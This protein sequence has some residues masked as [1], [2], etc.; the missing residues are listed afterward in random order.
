MSRSGGGHGE[1]AIQAIIAIA[2]QSSTSDSLSFVISSQSN[3]IFPDRVNHLV[4]VST[5][6]PDESLLTKQERYV[7]TES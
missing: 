5:Y 4:V 3:E 6:S 2:F 7:L 1:T